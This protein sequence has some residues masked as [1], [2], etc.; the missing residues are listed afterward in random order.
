[1]L[2]SQRLYE[3]KYT[4]FLLLHVIGDFMFH[5]LL[6]VVVKFV[7][8][9]KY[10]L[11]NLHQVLLHRKIPGSCISS[12]LGSAVDVNLAFV[13]IEVRLGGC[14]NASTGLVSLNFLFVSGSLMALN[15]FAIVFMMSP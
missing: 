13:N 15:K 9:C 12:C 14:F 1:M 5:V 11:H 4:T 3:K 8:G 10:N 6:F 2:P 7:T